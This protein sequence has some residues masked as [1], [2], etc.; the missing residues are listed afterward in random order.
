MNIRLIAAA[1]ALVLSAGAHA[2]VFSDNFDADVQGT[3]KT[4]VGWTLSAGTND[5]DIIGT[6]F[7]DLQPGNGNYIDLAGSNG[8]AG[9]A[10]LSKDFMVG[11]GTYTATFELAGNLRDGTTDIVTVLFGGSSLPVTLAPTAA[12]GTYSI[13]TTL[14]APGSLT[15]SFEDSRAGNIGALLDDVTVSAVPEAGNLSMMLAGL[16]ALG[17]A[18]RRRRG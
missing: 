10:I 3:D 11:A 15:L 2:A 13:T 5:V 17:F 14:A 18:A 9:A 7:Y 4:P 1:A 6:G 12:F 16:A 8:A